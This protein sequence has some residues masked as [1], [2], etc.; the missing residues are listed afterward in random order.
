MFVLLAKHTQREKIGLVKLF[1]KARRRRCDC[2]LYV[3]HKKNEL[4][5]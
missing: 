2:N 3:K 1:K 5:L 4:T